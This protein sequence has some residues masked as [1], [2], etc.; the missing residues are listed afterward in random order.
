M[1]RHATYKTSKK[2]AELG[3]VPTP[4]FAWW[5]ILPEQEEPVIFYAYEVEHDYLSANKKFIGTTKMFPAFDDYDTGRLLPWI[6]ETQKLKNNYW[7]CK[8]H[9]SIQTTGKRKI[10]QDKSRAEVELQATIWLKEN[11]NKGEIG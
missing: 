5:G 4:I 8:I 9:G 10:F 1:T 6:L 7:M 3:I 2:A 11:S